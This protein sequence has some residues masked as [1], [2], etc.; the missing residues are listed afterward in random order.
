MAIWQ[1]QFDVYPDRRSAAGIWP[2]PHERVVKFN[3]ALA[4]IL[5]R[6]RGWS[7]AQILFGDVSGHCFEMWLTESGHTDE[8]RLRLDAREG[9][10]LITASRC[11]SVITSFELALV[12]VESGER[13]WTKTQFAMLFRRSRAFAFVSNPAQYLDEYVVD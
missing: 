5:P 2:W 8:A 10:I 7:P 3:D 4:E 6:S 9:N 13:L 1:I 12:E 11:L